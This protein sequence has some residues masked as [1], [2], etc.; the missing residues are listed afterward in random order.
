MSWRRETSTSRK[1]EAVMRPTKGEPDEALRGHR[2]QAGDGDEGPDGEAGAE[3]PSED[4]AEHGPADVVD[5]GVRPGRRRRRGHHHHHGWRQA[6]REGG[7]AAD[8]VQAGGPA[9]GDQRA[10]TTEQVAL[11]LGYGL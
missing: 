4:R 2:Q 9:V 5:A 1:T 8:R 10:Y 6:K 11:I 7:A 3:R